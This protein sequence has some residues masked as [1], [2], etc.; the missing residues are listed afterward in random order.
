MHKKPEREPKEKPERE[1]QAGSQTGR[2]IREGQK[3]ERRRKRTQ[4]LMPARVDRLSICKECRG[5]CMFQK[6]WHQG[7]LRRAGSRPAPAASRQAPGGAVGHALGGA[8]HTAGPQEAGG[9]EGSSGLAAGQA[10]CGARDQ[11][12]LVDRAPGGMPAMREWHWTVCLA[13]QC[14][15]SAGQQVS[16]CQLTLCRSPC[17]C[18]TCTCQQGTW[19]GPCGSGTTGC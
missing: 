16:R 7:G 18:P 5:Q 17:Q 19:W 9:A 1:K 13:R 6:W 4:N 14:F 10:G 3:P 12:I 2:Y 11:R 8:G 15:G